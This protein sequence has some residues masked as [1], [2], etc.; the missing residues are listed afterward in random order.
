MSQITTHI[1]DT[2]LGKPAEGVDVILYLEQ[3]GNWSP[4]AN[5]ITNRDGR[6]SDLLSDDILLPA[7]AYKLR[8][9]LRPYFEQLGVEVFY[10]FAEIVFM[11]G[12][13]EHYHIPLLLNPYGYTTYRGS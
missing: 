1:L 13:H 10:P 11:V 2:S 8:F 5:G 4:F 7:G 12:G 9:E 3:Q 6:V